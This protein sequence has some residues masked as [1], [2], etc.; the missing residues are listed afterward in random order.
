VGWREVEGEKCPFSEGIELGD[1]GVDLERTEMGDLVEFV[2]LDMQEVR[3]LTGPADRGSYFIYR[4]RGVDCC[5]VPDGDVVGGECEA[6]AVIA[7]AE[8]G[9]LGWEGGKL[10]AACVLNHREYE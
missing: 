3:G 6:G 1:G 5:G 10:T 8:V 7:G 9:N 4:D 2:R